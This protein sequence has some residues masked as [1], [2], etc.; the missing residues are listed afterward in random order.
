MFS[1]ARHSISWFGA[2]AVILVLSGLL[3]PHFSPASKMPTSVKIT[4]FVLN[5]TGVSAT[6]FLLLRFFVFERDKERA[7]SERLLLNVLPASVAAR[8]RESEGTI[9]DGFDEVT[10]LFA[11]IVDFTTLSATAAPGEIV[12]LLNGLFSWFDRLAERHGL[13]KIKTIGDAYMVAGGLPVPRPDHAEAVADMALEMMAG[14]DSI[15]HELGSAIQPRI[16]IDTGP[17]WPAS[18]AS[19]D[20]STTCGA[21]RST[22]PVGWSPMISPA[23]SR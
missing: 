7:K 8:L 18:S 19:G 13:E 16:G 15:D 11:D 4:F 23:A 12:D 1:S 21:I 20:S 22:P 2:Y 6:A 5:L 3:D 14:L 17:A 10:V 9:A